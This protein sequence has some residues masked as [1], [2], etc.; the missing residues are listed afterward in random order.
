MVNKII[1]YIVRFIPLLVSL[2]VGFASLFPAALERVEKDKAEQ[3]ER[4][5]KL[6]AAYAAGEIEP[7]DEAG[8]FDGDLEK[9]LENGLK[10][11]ELRF[12]GTHNSY[13][14][15]PVE[16]FTQLYARLSE[17]TF[18]L[19]KAEKGTFNSQTLTQQLNCGIRSLEMDIET[20]DRDGEISF[21]CMHSPYFDM[22]TSCYDFELALKEIKMWSDNNPN[23]LPITIIIEPKETFLPLKDM[24]PINLDYIS[25]FDKVLR[26]GLGDK[27]FTPADMLRDYESFGA[28]RAADDWCKAQ[29][30]LGKVLI[31]LHENSATTEGYIAIDPSIKTQ[32]MFPMLR[33][34]DIERDCTSF[35]L[36]NT[37][38]ELIEIKDDVIFSKKIIARTRADKFTEIEAER[39]EKA[40]ASAA[41]IVSTDYPPRDDL[42]ADAYVVGFNGKHTVSTN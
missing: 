20:F 9:E 24:K 28:M 30:T 39:L 6:E 12:L 15:V 13:Q 41:Q 34:E 33:E 4:I 42:A 17:L 29:D 23:H 8:F 36:A 38:G 27:L 11:N 37:P 32:A 18:G 21:T 5:A 31:L 1:K 3:I 25:E 26:K 14:P 2:A 19:V 35:I 16:E 22:A 10:F 40:M 7:V